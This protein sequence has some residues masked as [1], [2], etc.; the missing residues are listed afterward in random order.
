MVALT[1]VPLL[2]PTIS[3]TGNYNNSSSSS[4]SRKNG[5]FFESDT[6]DFN[7]LEAHASHGLAG[8][9]LYHTK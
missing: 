4:N 5:T 8:T 2:S 9:I 3:R 6:R 7:E 1:W